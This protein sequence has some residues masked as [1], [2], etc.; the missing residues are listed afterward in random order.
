MSRY[1]GL[2]APKSRG[3]FMFWRSA[4]VVCMLVVIGFTYVASSYVEYNWNWKQVPQYFWLDKTIEV[5]AEVAGDIEKIIKGPEG[6]SISIMDGA[7]TETLQAPADAEILL[8]EGDYA[9]EGD[10]VASYKVSQPGMLLIS[11]WITLKVSFFAIIIG[12]TLGI[13]TGLSRVSENPLLKWFS[14]IYIELIRGTPL[15]VQIFLWYFVVGNL[16]N[17]FLTQIGIGGVPPLWF[18][19]IALATFTGAYTA[20][21][22]RAGIQSVHRGQMEAARSL[23]LTYAE[24]MRKVILP[25]ALR[26]I[27]PPLAG[28]F[29][30]LI[31]DSSLLGVIAIREVTKATRE[32]VSSSLMPYE[33]WITCA[34][35]YLVL[36]FALSLCVQHLER[37][38]LR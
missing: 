19:V 20:E 38:S 4:I 14:I 18:G 30:S 24:S 9:Y 31:K 22:V 6:Y 25:Q 35:L 13:L 15:M 37:K 1:S 32:I 28:Q 21:I 36:T 26:R 17:A 7:Y 2:D 27:M 8:T 34:L 11:L 33:M 29:I 10:L 16:I 5:R 12:I 23:G 3:Y